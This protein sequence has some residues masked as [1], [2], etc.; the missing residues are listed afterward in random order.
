M[1]KRE[2]LSR[3]HTALGAIERC[4]PYY[5]A[6]ADAAAKREKM[7]KDAGAWSYWR[8]VSIIMFG[9]FIWFFISIFTMKG[10]GEFTIPF[11]IL[12]LLLGAAPFFLFRKMRADL[13]GL[14]QAEEQ[15]KAAYMRKRAAEQT[16][17][18]LYRK[19]M[20]EPC[21]QPRY[22]RIFIGYLESGRADS[23]K[24][25]WSLFEEMLHREQM[26]DMAAEQ[27]EMLRQI[28][29]RPRN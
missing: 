15:A 10:S 7:Q 20:P 24:E 11:S 28:R 29:R 22:A 9:A 4:Y 23:A 25:A 12:F 13:P 17:I 1:D 3:L 18:D 19:L 16:G 2:L 21:Y 8:F 14:E 26:E 6:W 27:L 5:Q